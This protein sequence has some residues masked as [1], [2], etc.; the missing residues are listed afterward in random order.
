MYAL[1]SFCSANPS[2]EV[3]K[4]ASEGDGTE[5][6]MLLRMGDIDINQCDY[7]KRTALYLAAG[8]GHVDVVQYLCTAGVNVN[9]QDRWNNRPLDDA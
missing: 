9:V 2:Q 5:V 4:N 3:R 6:M 1:I 8:E 7:D